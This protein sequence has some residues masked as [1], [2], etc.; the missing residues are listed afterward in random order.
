MAHHRTPTLSTRDLMAI[1]REAHNQWDA[2]LKEPLPADMVD[3]LERLDLYM[4]SKPITR[5]AA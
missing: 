5:E 2:I 1:G 4:N 3:G